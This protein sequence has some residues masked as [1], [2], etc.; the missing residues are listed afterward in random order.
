MTHSRNAH[1][2][3]PRATSSDAAQKRARQCAAFI[4][5][6]RVERGLAQATCRAYASDLQGFS[7]YCEENSVAA[8]GDVT[9]QHIVTYLHT[10]H[11]SGCSTQTI[12]RCMVTL[13][14]F[15]RYL[16]A[17]GMTPV[18][19]TE[20]VETPKLWHMLPDVLSEDDVMRLLEAPDTSTLTGCRDY[21]MLELLYATGL[22]VSEL[23]S[24]RI[25]DVTLSDAFLRCTGKGKKDRVVPVGSHACRAI[26][27]YLSLREEDT[28]PDA[29]LFITR[30]GKKMSRVNFW[31]RVQRYAR[32]AGIAQAVYP[33]VLR[34]SFATHL[35]S[36]GADLRIVQEMLGHADISTTQIYTHMDDQRLRDAH[37][38]FHPRG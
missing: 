30:L 25:R 24:L 22:R 34:H 6:L 36:H 29:A 8:W 13:R 37:T 33:H 32:Q 19:V 2:Q 1:R 4:T 5:Y 15:Y 38:K 12:V 3:S 21:A 10:R 35:L 11:K 28:P 26:K 18:D 17:E 14:M 9:P 7:A 31:K 20:R 16:V 27:A 23:V